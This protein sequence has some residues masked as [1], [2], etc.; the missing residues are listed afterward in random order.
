MKALYVQYRPKNWAEVVGQDK[1]IEKVKVLARRG[2][3]GKAF[4]V[5][6]QS[7]TG[8]TTIANLIAAE[9]ANPEGMKE[10]IGR[11]LTINSLKEIVYTWSFTPWSGRGHALIV[12]EAHGMSR[13]VIEWFL[14][15]L[16]YIA[17]ENTRKYGGGQ[18]IMP[19]VVIFTTTC[20]GNDL[21][22][23]H[24]DANPFSSRVIGLPLA[25]RD[26][27]KAFAVRC[28]EIAEAEK[29]DGKPVEAYVKLAQDCGNNFRKMLQ[30]I[31][32]GEML[33]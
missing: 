26:L 23:E 27:A 5:T 9:V 1:A 10:V 13:P 7:G 14:D 3:E 33:S 18:R 6:G 21:F 29:L 4:W 30:K 32:S 11:E 20:E 12:N 31:E 8:K 28:K 22:E 17:G 24:I 16:E 15:V 25:R 2:L 19:V